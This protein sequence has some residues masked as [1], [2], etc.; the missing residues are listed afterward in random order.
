MLFWFRD[1]CHWYREA[2][3]FRVRAPGAVT[4]RTG[5][6]LLTL[7][8]RIYRTYNMADRVSNLLIWSCDFAQGVWKGLVKGVVRLSRV[9]IF[10][11][12]HLKSKL[13]A[14]GEKKNSTHRCTQTPTSTDTNRLAQTHKEVHVCL[15]TACPCTHTHTD[16]NSWYG[17]CPPYL[18]VIYDCSSIEATVIWEMMTILIW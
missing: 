13:R 17:L 16:T 18:V 2:T 5:V 1:S 6:L 11:L 7:W 15:C 14:S 8:R 12:L 9:S 4:H 3:L 10:R